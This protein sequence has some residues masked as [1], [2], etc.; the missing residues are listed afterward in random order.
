MGE[1]RL[2]TAPPEF[3]AYRDRTRAFSNLA[4]YEPQSFDLTGDRAPE[5]I[6]GYAVTASLFPTLQV[7][8][9]I[10]RLFSRQEEVPGAPKVVVL[11]YE[12]WRRHYAEDQSVIG[13]L[14]RLSEQPYQ[15]VAVM[16]R[17]FTF[18]ATAATPGEP[19]SFWTPLAFTGQQLTDWA[20][21]FDTSVIARLRPGVSLAQASDDAKRVADEFERE[22]SDIYSG[23]GRLEVAVEPWAPD[24]GP[25]TRLVL[26]MLLGA[27][28]FLL[29][30]ACANVANLLLARAGARQR[31]MSIRRAIGASAGR[32][33]RQVLTETAVLTLGGGIAGCL[34]AYAMLRAISSVAIK[35]VNVAAASMNMRVLFFTFAVCAVT[36]VLCGLAPA[37]MFR[38]S[39]MHEALRQ[40][41]RQSGS[42]RANRK[43]AR[44][45][46]VTEIACCVLLLI[47]SGLLL[48]SFAR[49]LAVP[50]GFDPEHALIV[51]TTFNHN[52]YA[53]PE[54]RHA[55]EHAIQGRLESLPGVASLALTTHVPLAD[56]RQIGFHIDGAPPDEFHWADN[57]LVSGD[58]FRVMKI[59]LL[60]GRTFSDGDSLRSPLVAVIN[61][62]MAG[63]YWPKQDAIGKTFQWGG[64]PISVIAVAG[65]IHIQAVDQ[66]IGPT[67]YNSV[68]QMESG[69]SANG[70]FVIRTRQDPMLLA[71]AAQNAIWSVDKGLPILGFSTLDQ[72]VSGSLAIRRI[73]VVLIG[74]FALIALL[75]A[76]VGIYGLLSYAVMQRVQEMGLRLALG[77]RP[78]AI[79]TLVIGEG[80]RLAVMGIALGVAGG[81]IAT[82]Y[83]A[84]LLFGVRSFDPLSFVGGALLLLVVCCIASYLPAR[85]AAR[86][87]PMVALRYE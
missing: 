56:E 78:G 85:R 32:L 13:K 6:S 81:L 26:L 82:R 11:S 76:V 52:R 18:P 59:P 84:N 42:S 86:V 10:G 24:F 54:R 55:A 69:A 25:A 20:S 62:S 71:S 75:L 23:A 73:S 67:I 45:L 1:L 8:P 51:R 15:V 72:V 5:H 60:A 35:E 68:Y 22:H 39:G 77:A 58:Y 46:I 36:C 64:R 49:M 44:L 48:R 27:V 61:Q 2:G 37:W 80:M 38:I 63:K 19:P 66:P 83:I 41:A 57:A 47:G 31:E 3:A 87:D 30:I 43:I 74:A 28:A 4:G 9:L 53:S 21:S 12:F 7:E 34:L 29:L 40:S 17:G 50:L 14:I 70:V 79:A 16:P 33:T 65:D